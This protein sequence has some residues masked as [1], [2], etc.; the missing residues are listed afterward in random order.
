[1]QRVRYSEVWQVL[2][3]GSDLPLVTGDRAFGPVGTPCLSVKL[4]WAMEFLGSGA[5]TEHFV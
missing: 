1:M 4:L 2:K 5:G 3:E